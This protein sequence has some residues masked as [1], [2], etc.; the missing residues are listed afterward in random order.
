MKDTIRLV[1]SAAVLAALLACD[2]FPSF[3]PEDDGMKKLDQARALWMAAGPDR[4]RYAIRRNCFCPEGYVGPVVMEV[5]GGVATERLYVASGDPVPQEIASAFPTV[6]GLFTIL[7]EAI[8]EGAFR[9]AVTYDPLLGYP[10]GVSIDYDE[11]AVDE[12]LG[13]EVTQDVEGL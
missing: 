10:R 6:D 9:V 12:E 3:G 1:A 7:E 5:S 2:I 8:S 11:H 13:F 4:Y